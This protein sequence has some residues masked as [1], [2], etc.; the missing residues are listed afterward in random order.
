MDISCQITDCNRQNRMESIDSV[1]DPVY[2]SSFP[3]VS[4]ALLPHAAAEEKD[5]SRGGHS[6]EGR[7]D[8]PP[9]HAFV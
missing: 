2:V 4:S 6:G 1:I 9:P 7:L 8:K 5:S 3:S